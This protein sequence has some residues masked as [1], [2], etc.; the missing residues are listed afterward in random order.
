MQ[1]LE[2][3]PSLIDYPSTYPSLAP[4]P[5]ED[6]RKASNDL[7]QILKREP[8]GRHWLDDPEEILFVWVLRMNL[9]SKHHSL[10]AAQ[11]AIARQ[12]E[13][14]IQAKKRQAARSD[15]PCNSFKWR[16]NDKEISVSG[17]PQVWR[18]L[19]YLWK[20]N[21]KSASFQ[22]LAEPVYGDRNEEP[23]RGSICS[24]R[25]KANKFFKRK[26]IPWRVGIKANQVS[27]ISSEKKEN[28]KS[29]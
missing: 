14:D 15:G 28:P 13:L 1:H 25:A 22:E 16:H 5:E 7:G 23:S 17:G 6:I 3:Y 9:E 19:D 20:L 21:G 27:L 26:K 4:P 8:Y 18:L 2:S 12:M 29:V 10:A 24:M 11:H